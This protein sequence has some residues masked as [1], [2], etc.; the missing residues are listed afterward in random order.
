MRIADPPS[1]ADLL[2]TLDQTSEWDVLV[3][4]GG[5]TGLGVA[6]DAAARGYR[7]LL[8]EAHDFAQGT[9]SKAT[10]LVHG[11]VRYLAQGNI[12]LV[13]E[14]LRERGL[15]ARNAPHL[16]KKLGFLVPAFRWRDQLLYGAGLTVYD[17]LAGKLGF[18]KSRLLG[19]AETRAVLPTLNETLQGHPLR[20]STLYY[21]GQ[22]DD[23]RLAISLMRT[24]FD[25]G[26]AA[27]NHI[28]VTGVAAEG[29]PGHQ[30]VTVKDRETGG[31]L[32][33]RSRCV[34][35]ATGVWVD[36]I[37]AMVDPGARPIVAPSQGVHL[38][39]AGKFLSS[40]HALMVPKTDDGRV[41]FVVPWHGHAIVGTTDT[42]RRDLPVEPRATEEEIDFILR[43][44][45]RY[46]TIPPTRADVLSV[47]AG[48]RPLVRGDQGASTAALSREHTVELHRG[49]MI[50]VTGGKWTTYRH[51]AEE[52]IDL[53]IKNG[54]LS[55][56]P[57]RTENLPLHARLS[58][59][60]W[61]TRKM[62]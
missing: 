25:L 30:R 16:V 14:A 49:G 43:T 32:T 56:A 61:P 3:I 35:N 10:K 45:A 4:G 2:R 15:L 23:A 52:V 21:D 37:R 39:V 9:S 36:A 5:A 18:T 54:L 17:L 38:T 22:F 50:T 8:L 60:W 59:C 31:E 62:I 6:V 44:A 20:G 19:A 53:A 7:T 13:R 55:A 57:C 42:P 34:V 48:L 27:L 41:M 58:V 47:W 11:G 24:I 26:G 51:M 40:R 33:V 28:A 46:L 12:S 1:R 29:P